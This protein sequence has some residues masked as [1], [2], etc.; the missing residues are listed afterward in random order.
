MTCREVLLAIDAYL[1]EE[2][3]VLET[4]GVQEHLDHCEACRRVVESE[5]TLHA[6][7]AADAVRDAPPGG[8]RNRILEQARAGE[9]RRR[10]WG[11]WRPRSALHLIL[12]G[13]IAAALL[14]GILLVLASRPVTT[15]A[16]ARH[17]DGERALAD[18]ELRTTNAGDVAAW[19]ETRLG[20]RVSFPG[21][22]PGGERLVGARVSSIGSQEAAQ[23]LYDRHGR[24]VSLFITER[25]FRLRERAQEHAVEGVEVYLANLRGVRVAWWDEGDHLYVVA[26]RAS[27]AEVLDFAGLCVRLARERRLESRDPPTLRSGALAPPA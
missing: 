2:L 9:P 18:F 22:T 15:D 4:R 13:G 20:L 16:V 10:F 5:A 7:L 6:L 27:E 26:A 17:L 25:A 11:D 23:L 12:A 1:D 3:G 19:L 14:V 8:L 21:A 24:R